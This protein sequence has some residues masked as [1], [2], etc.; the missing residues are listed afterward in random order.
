MKGLALEMHRM[1]MLTIILRYHNSGTEFYKP[2]AAS[3]NSIQDEMGC[4]KTTASITARSL[5]NDGL[6]TIDKMHVMTPDG[7]IRGT[8]KFPILTEKGYRYVKENAF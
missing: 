5:K 8:M 2:Q 7:K 3:M 6:I 1:E 4:K